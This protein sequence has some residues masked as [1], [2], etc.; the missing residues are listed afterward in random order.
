MHTESTAIRTLAIKKEYSQWDYR[1]KILYR[2]DIKFWRLMNTG[3][4][5]SVHEQHCDL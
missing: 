2:R 4:I 1:P 3:A 5:K